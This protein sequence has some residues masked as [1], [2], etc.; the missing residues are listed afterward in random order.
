M[1]KTPQF[2]SM[3]RHRKNYLVRDSSFAC[4]LAITYFPRGYAP[5]IIGPGT[6]GGRAFRHIATRDAYSL[7]CGFLTSVFGIRK[8]DELF[9]TLRPI[10]HS[11]A[12]WIERVEPRA[13][14]T[15]I[16]QYD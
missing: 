13:Q 7:Q 10:T 3:I 8:A 14:D 12:V 15:S 4:Y 9:A 1:P 5:S 2:Y 16:L 11:P 6:K